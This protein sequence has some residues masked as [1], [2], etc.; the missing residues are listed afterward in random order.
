MEIEE[1]KG[2]WSEMSEELE[3]QKILTNKL[4][5][6]MTQQRIQRK[7]GGISIP[8]SIGAG[9]CFLAGIL[10]LFNFNEFDT[11]YLRLCGALSLILLI[12][13]PAASLRSIYKMKN[14]DF[15]NNTYKESLLR[16]LKA[17]QHF[18]TI[19]RFAVVAAFG[20]MLI[21]LPVASKLIKG[22]D[23]FL[24]PTAWYWYIP[25]MG[26]F[27]FLFTRWVLN[28]YKNITT[29]AEEMFKELDKS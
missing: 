14:V 1:M 3:Q 17:K 7:L 28:A 10:I 20:F 16:F 11:W 19:Q 18:F 6:E 27:L 26:I 9:I 13:L 23:L 24:E 2:L 25:V 4:I 29:S 8:E 5:E 15:I 21:S 22:K 12:G